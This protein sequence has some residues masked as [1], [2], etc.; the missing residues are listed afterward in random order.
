MQLPQEPELFVDGLSTTGVPE[1]MSGVPAKLYARYSIL[2][3]NTK[4]KEDMTFLF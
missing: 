1:S 3:L 2:R 4:L